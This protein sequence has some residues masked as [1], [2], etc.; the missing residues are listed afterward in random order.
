MSDSAVLSNGGTANVNASG[1]TCSTLYLGS[2]NIVLNEPGQLSAS[3]E[4]ISYTGTGIFTQTGG[5]NNVTNAIWLG[6]SSGVS[7]TYN[8]SGGSLSA[9][10][11]D[12][13]YQ[14]KGVFIQSGGTNIFQILNVG[15]NLG[16]SGTYS[17]SGNGVLT[18]TQESIGQSGGSGV[19]IQSGGTNSPQM[20]ILER[21]SAPAARTISA[22]GRYLPVPRASVFQAAAFSSRAA[23]PTVLPA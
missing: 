5:T 2:G 17:L 12:V 3:T 1:A 9:F 18:G 11:E 6:Y 22:A 4:N 10:I 8:L 20:L 15:D 16:I 23:E 19:F 14:G 7:G 13:G 21:A